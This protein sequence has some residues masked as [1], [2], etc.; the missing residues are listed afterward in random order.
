VPLHHRHGPCSP[1]ASKKVPVLEE[2]L[3][4]DQLR[5]SNIQQ[6]LSGARK[7]AVI[8]PR[9]L[10]SASVPTKLATSLDSLQYVI[11]VRL[12]SP[13]V[14]QTV[15]MDTGSDVSWVQCVP[16]SKCYPQADPLFDPRSSSTYSPF[17]CGSVACAQLGLDGGCSTSAQC[18]YIVRY[19]DGS[20]TTGTYSSDTLALGTDALVQGFEFGCSHLESS[21]EHKI[22]GLVGLGG[23][24]QSLVSQTA[25]T[26]GSAFSYCLPPTAATSGFLT[27]GAD[28]ANSAAFV[29]TPMHRSLRY[30]TFYFVLLEAIAVGGTVLDVPPSV[31]SAGSIMDSGTIIT[32]LP[33]TAYAALSRAFRA[34]MRQYPAAAPSVEI[35][36]TCFDFSGHSTVTVPAVSLVFSG[37]TVVNLDSSGII[38]GGCLAFAPNNNDSSVGIIGNVQQRTFEVLHDVRNGA[39]GFRAGAC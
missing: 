5:A 31:F 30:P 26:F 22:A 19:G 14:T 33:A 32:R 7:G 1:V 29:V 36:D 27:L 8:F 18:Q 39:I 13:G 37:G 35:F 11:T 21:F 3:R 17:P 23:D 16:C 28:A 10:V 15:L 2:L 25:A 9:K 12:G 24:V 20:N 38:L 6:K 34:G 4:H